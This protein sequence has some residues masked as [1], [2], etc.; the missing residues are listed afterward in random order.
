MAE[1]G[2][3]LAADVLVLGGGMAAAWAAIAAARNGANVIMADKGYVGTSGV[4]ATAGP[5]H[6]WVPPERREEV[7]AQRLISSQGLGHAGW[8]KRI[9]AQTWAQLPT[10]GQFYEFCV[11]DEGAIVYGSV[12]GPEYMR[13]LRQLAESRGVRI[14]DHSPALELLLHRD[15]SAAGARGWRRQAHEPWEVRAGAVVLATGGCA[16]HSRLLGSRNNTGDGYLMAAEAGVPLSGMEFSSLYTVAPAFST[17]ARAMSY[18]Y[19]TY[20]DSSGRRLELPREPGNN[21][22]LARAL[23]QGPV[24]CDLARMPQDIRDRLPYISPNI[25]PPFHRHGIDPFTDKFPVTLLAEGTIRGVGGLKIEDDA[26][27]TATPGLYAAGDVASRELVTGAISGGGAVNAA[28]ALSSGTW[29]GQAAARRAMLQGQRAEAPAEAI[30]QAG[31][32]PAGSPAKLDT[33]I[34]SATVR[35]QA[36]GFDTTYFRTAQSLTQ[37]LNVLNTQWHS[38]R[39]GLQGEGDAALPAREAAALTATARWCLTAALH[40]QESRGMHTREDFPSATPALAQ[41]QTLRGLDAIHSSFA[42]FLELAA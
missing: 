36:T 5:G 15:G 26:C 10:L 38:L 12:R 40:R 17:M 18:V 4:T 34:L 21:R 9:I 1:P 16:F 32:R 20:Y 19:A 37:A 22:A 7:V 39:A 3:A 14:L 11:N 33:A 13:A 24:F 6:W 31:L 23:Q 30:G 35:A 41:P 29:S 27:Q 28:W 25:L 42:P 2:L 8:M